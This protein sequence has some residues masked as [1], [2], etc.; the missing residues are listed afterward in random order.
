[1]SGKYIYQWFFISHLSNG[2]LTNVND[3]VSKASLLKSVLESF[4]ENDSSTA[5]T[6]S[7][8]LNFF[9]VASYKG[10]RVKK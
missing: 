4:I 9:F 6:S 10:V 2:C 3:T 7:D 5:C 8:F 1:M